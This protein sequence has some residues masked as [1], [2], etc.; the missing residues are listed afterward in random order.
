MCIEQRRR[1]ER[2]RKKGL[3]NTKKQEEIDALWRTRREFALRSDPW[4]HK[5]SGQESTENTH[6]IKEATLVHRQLFTLFVRVPTLPGLHSHLDAIESKK[7]EKGKG[8]QGGVLCTRFV[9]AASKAG[10][11]YRSLAQPLTESSKRTP[12]HQS[13]GR[14]RQHA[15]PSDEGTALL[16]F[17]L[18]RLIFD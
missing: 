2:E 11:E 13:T 6:K 10:D 4:P 1:N 15:L 7:V 18:K 9:C 16:L 8:G 17:T 14:R 3:K 12:H 5:Q